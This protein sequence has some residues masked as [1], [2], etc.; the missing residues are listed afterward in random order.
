[1]N[2]CY[3]RYSCNTADEYYTKEQEYLDEIGPE[4]SSLDTEYGNALLASPFRA[5]LEKAL[6]PV[7]FRYLEVA[8]KAMSPMIVE[9]MVEENKLVSEYSK[10]MAALE[11]EFRGESSPGR[12]WPNISRTTTGRPGGRL[13][14]SLAR[15]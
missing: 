4:M 14:R 15:R 10:Y 1:M 6:S 2:L 7:Y 9:D 11:F 12:R 5:E 3:I 13:I 8:S